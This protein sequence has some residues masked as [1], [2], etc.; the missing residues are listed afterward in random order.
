MAGFTPNKSRG[1]RGEVAELPLTGG[2][3]VEPVLADT[4]ANLQARG[5]GN[6]G[7]KVGTLAKRTDTQGRRE[8]ECLTLAEASSTWGYKEEFW[9]DIGQPSSSNSNAER[10]STFNAVTLSSALSSL[11]YQHFFPRHY[12]AEVLEI[13]PD[14]GR[15]LFAGDKGPID[16]S[17]FK[18]GNATA[19][20]TDTVD[21]GADTEG[22]F[23]IEG[24]F[25]AGEWFEIGIDPTAARIGQERHY[26]FVKARR[27]V[28]VTE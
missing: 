28:T 21:P 10:W 7:V 22:N 25:N 26:C 20:S 3:D 5:S 24:S 2:A 4:L 6:S 15:I 17:L 1:F 16:V 13:L 9:L 27:T 23:S 11:A 18:N 12:D 19:I 14:T 8:L